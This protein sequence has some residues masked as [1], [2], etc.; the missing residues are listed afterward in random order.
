MSQ[1]T[2][3]PIANVVSSGPG[4]GFVTYPQALAQLPF[5]QVWSFLFFLMLLMIGL[6]SQFLSME[7]VV[8]AMVDQYPQRLYKWRWLVT[9]VFCLISYLLTIGFCTQGGPYMFQLVDWYVASLGPLVFCTLECVAV[10]WIY[11]AK[12]FSSDVEMMTGKHLSPAVKVLLAFVT[13]AILLIVFILTTISYQPPT[14]GKY[15]FPSYANIIGWCFAVLP[16]LPLPV[17]LITARVK[18]ALQPDKNWCPA[19]ANYKEAHMI[20]QQ[21]QRHTFKENIFD[22]FK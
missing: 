10:M 6:D 12:R 19:N 16:L 15:E 3:V 7:V 21:T 20:N 11:G 14:Y 8:T 4:L 13:P 9:L 5:P 22:V 17:F 2:G 18:L 1:K